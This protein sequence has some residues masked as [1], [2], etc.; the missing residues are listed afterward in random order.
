MTQ[1]KEDNGLFSW[2][3]I[4]FVFVSA[5]EIQ[6]SPW[7]NFRQVAIVHEVLCFGVSTD[8]EREPV[9]QWNSAGCPFP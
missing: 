7:D 8:T 1:H 6:L 9:N 4:V 5:A 3:I 2:N